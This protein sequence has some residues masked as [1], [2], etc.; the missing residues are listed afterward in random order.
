[1]I[2]SNSALYFQVPFSMMKVPGGSLTAEKLAAETIN[3]I[4]DIKKIHNNAKDNIVNEINLVRKSLTTS[5]ED[6]ASYQYK[7]RHDK[8]RY[9]PVFLRL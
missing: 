4:S 9:Y 6:D 2:Y 8:F 5:P 7:K 3:Q 1:M